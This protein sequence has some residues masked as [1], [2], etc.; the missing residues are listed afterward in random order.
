MTLH[1]RSTLPAFPSPSPRRGWQKPEHCPQSFVPRITPQH[2]W[3]GTPGHHRARIGSFSPY[4]IL[5]HRPYRVSQG[6]A[7]SPPWSQPTEVLDLVIA[8]LP[9]L[10][11]MDPHVRIRR[12]ERQVI[13][14][15]EAMDHPCGAVVS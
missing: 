8:Y 9:V 7:C 14:K 4:S 11:A 6:C 10:E 3:V 2:V 13:D 12:I 5:L 15:A 1:L